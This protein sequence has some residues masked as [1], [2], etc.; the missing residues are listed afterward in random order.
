MRLIE[1]V[2]IGG[3]LMAA[4]AVALVGVTVWVGAA[5]AAPVL[6]VGAPGGPGEGTYADY[7][8]GTDPTEDDTAFTSGDTILV[9][10]TYQ[11]PNVSNL[12]GQFGAGLNWSSFGLPTDFNTHDAILLVSVPDGT[13]AAALAS[14]TVDGIFAFYSSEDQSFFPNNHAPVQDA[15]ADFLFFDI[16]EFDDL[17]AMP[18]FDDETTGTQLGEIKSLLIAGFGDLDWIHFD[19]M[20]LETSEQGQTNVVTSLEN[21]PG[22]HDVTWKPDGDGPGPDPEVDIPEPGTLT[23]F[24]AGL[25]GVALWLRR[26]RAAA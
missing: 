19:V 5:N 8:D 9:G 20:A 16:G 22:S 21:N 17:I 26:R 3:R 11:N 12:G 10:G 24:G 13:L 1:T 2:W 6:Q 7:G 18:D 15:I 25:V 23:L 14:L 4:C